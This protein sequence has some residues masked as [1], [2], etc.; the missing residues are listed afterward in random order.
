MPNEYKS[1]YEAQ[2]AEQLKA[3]K[4]K[5]QYEPYPMPY[6]LPVRGGQCVFCRDSGQPHK[7]VQ[8]H[9][10]IPDW[11]SEDNA[12]VVESK[13][14]FTGAMRTK[15]LAV[16]ENHP[17]VDIR[18]LFMRDNTLSKKSET[19]YSDWCEKNGIEF[20]IGLFPKAWL[21]DFKDHQVSGNTPKKRGGISGR[22]KRGIA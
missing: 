15:M 17:S 4:V 5:F 11:V 3:A 13:G 10:Y 21:K 1:L 19:R 14:K 22:A 9:N 6:E 12:I 20:A 18:M 7:V 8:W 16:I 2:L